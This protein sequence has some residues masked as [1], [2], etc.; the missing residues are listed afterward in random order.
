[1]RFAAA[2]TTAR[3]QWQ[4]RIAPGSFVNIVGATSSS[5]VYSSFETDFA[6]QMGA[7]PAAVSFTKDGDSY[8]GKRFD[9]DLRIRAQ[10]AGCPDTF[11]DPRTVK[12]IVAVDP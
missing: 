2:A 8:V 3:H 10:R 4:R 12:K 7:S 6:G 9:V 1:M 11:S 5:L